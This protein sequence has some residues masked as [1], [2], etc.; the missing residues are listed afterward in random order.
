MREKQV[1]R[2]N[3]LHESQ[4]EEGGE[5]TVFPASKVRVQEREAAEFLTPFDK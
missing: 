1:D 2:I 5:F 4:V 3:V